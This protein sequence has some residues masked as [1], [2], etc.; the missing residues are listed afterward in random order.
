MRTPQNLKTLACFILLFIFSS[1]LFAETLPDFPEASPEKK[2]FVGEK[3]IYEIYYLGIPVGQSVSEVKEIATVAGR[4]AYHF[5]VQVH[6]YKVM[7]WI[8]KVRDEH[9]SFV[10]VE[11]LQSL[12]YQKKLQEGRRHSYERLEWDPDSGGIREYDVQG[13]VLREMKLETPMQDALSCGYWS[14]TLD[15]KPGETFFVPVFAEGKAWNLQVKTYEKKPMILSKVGRFEAVRIEPLMEFTGIFFRKGKV[16]G[17]VSL[18]GRRIPLKMKVKI[19]VL[20]SISA[21]LVRYTPGES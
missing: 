5:Q 10:D 3:L 4:K 12:K 21:E 17:W 13:K 15:F 11:T 6:S 14:R 19:P 16:E 7:D 9:H 2:F 20:G 18:D 1:N 8:Y